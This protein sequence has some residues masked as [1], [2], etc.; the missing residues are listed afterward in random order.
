MLKMARL[1]LS[2]II[3]INL[4]SMGLLPCASQLV[5]VLL[6]A[7]ESAGM[8]GVLVT[9][10]APALEAEC[11]ARQDGGRREA[12]AHSAE[13]ASA[14]SQPSHSGSLQAGLLLGGGRLLCLRG[15]VSHPWLFPQ[16]AVVLHHAG[17]GTTAAA[18][19]AGIPQ[20][21]CPFIFDQ[22][23]W[24]GLLASLGC[25]P[26]PLAPADLLQTAPSKF[27]TS[28]LA[29]QHVGAALLAAAA[30][31]PAEQQLAREVRN[32]V[33]HCMINNGGPCPKVMFCTP[34]YRCFL[35]IDIPSLGS[36]ALP[37]HCTRLSPHLVFRMQDGVAVAVR[38]LVPES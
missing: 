1:F 31:R 13:T 27:A 2:L 21:T 3:P 15:P 18:I 16:C 17:S 24:A 30:L 34:R 32:E 35:E 12:Q 26:P 19:Q 28:A 25:S 11:Q 36:S 9:S 29:G 5:S 6:A 23:Y 14:H 10:T 20:V 8:A 37:I 4:C 7:L 22:F 33:S 38:H